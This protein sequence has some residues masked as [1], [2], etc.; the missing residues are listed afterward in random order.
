MNFLPTDG[1]FIKPLKVE[2]L[3]GEQKATK[4]CGVD[5]NVFAPG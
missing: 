2:L 5:S 4:I 1:F 3:A